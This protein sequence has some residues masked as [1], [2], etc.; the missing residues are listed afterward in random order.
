[1][2]NAISGREQIEKTHEA[3]KTILDL[4]VLLHKLN[5]IG[6]ISSSFVSGLY[7]DRHLPLFKKKV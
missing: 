2:N 6:F 5:I 7:L 1:M 4:R 3:K